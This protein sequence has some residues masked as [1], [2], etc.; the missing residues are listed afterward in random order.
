M[1][2]IINP[3]TK[4]KIKSNGATA[5]IPAVRARL[6][7]HTVRPTKRTGCDGFS[8][9]VGSKLQVW[10]GT[11]AKTPG[12]VT[13]AGLIKRKGR[14]LFESRSLAAKANPVLMAKAREMKRRFA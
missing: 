4:R 6:A 11:A 2:T 1:A 12:G 8:V 7:G 13:R 5:K 3:I 14:V 10:H 9:C